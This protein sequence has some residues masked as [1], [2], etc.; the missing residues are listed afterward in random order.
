MGFAG[1]EQDTAAASERDGR[2]GHQ[3]DGAGVITDGVF[4]LAEA[5]KGTGA[6]GVGGGIAGGQEDRA[7]EVADGLFGQREGEEEVASIV[8][9]CGV[10]REE[11]DGAIEVV[12]GELGLAGAGIGDS[13][14]VE[15]RAAAVVGQ[16]LVFEGFGILRDGLGRVAAQEIGGGILGC[17]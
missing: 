10:L 5:V 1:G 16:C 4:G 9:G 7:V 13:A 8:V 6:I 2:L 3:L 15:D 14:V 12:D 11:L 17:R